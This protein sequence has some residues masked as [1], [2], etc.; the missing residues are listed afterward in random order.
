MLESG[1]IYLKSKHVCHCGET[2]QTATHC[3]IFA[4]NQPN[5]LYY[6][7]TCD[8]VHDL[9][10]RGIKYDTK[11]SPYVEKIVF[12]T[13]CLLDYLCVCELFD[14]IEDSIN[15]IIQS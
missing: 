4:L 3:T 1:N 15:T 14:R 2:E 6:S 12:N 13:C 11:K 8:R 10:P 9:F 5:S 7:Q